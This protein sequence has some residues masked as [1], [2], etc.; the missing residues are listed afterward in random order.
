MHVVG[1]FELFVMYIVL[2][3][4]KIIRYM[5]VGE[6]PVT[7]DSVN[8]KYASFMK[9]SASKQQKNGNWSSQLKE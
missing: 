7:R 5:Y 8:K 2:L 9:T 4:L 1:V 3:S 6:N